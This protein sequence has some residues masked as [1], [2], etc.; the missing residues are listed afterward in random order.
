MGLPLDAIVRDAL[1]DT[2]GRRDFRVELGEKE[3]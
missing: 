3:I 2:A 1:E